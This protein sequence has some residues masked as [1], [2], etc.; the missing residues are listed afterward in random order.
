MISCIHHYFEC[1]SMLACRSVKIVSWST[2]HLWW[3]MYLFTD[4]CKKTI[5]SVYT[6][7]YSQIMVK[8]HEQDGNSFNQNSWWLKI[9][10]DLMWLNN[11]LRFFKYYY[12]MSF[13]FHHITQLS[14]RASINPNCSCVV[15][16][17]AV[18]LVTVHIS[19]V[20]LLTYLCTPDFEPY[21]G[22]SQPN[23]GAKHGLQQMWATAMSGRPMSGISHR[24]CSIPEPFLRILT[25]ICWNVYLTSMAD[26]DGLYHR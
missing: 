18:G 2:L 16:T 15:M 19:S 23:S 13:T 25:F 22:S 21:I 17:G 7:Y 12:N 20:W 10:Y 24:K 1:F 3:L 8:K 6:M 9:S 5:I 26:S 4:K 11:L 14:T